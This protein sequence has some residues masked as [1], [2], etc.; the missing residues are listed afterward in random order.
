MAVNLSTSNDAK[1]V[2]VHELVIDHIF[3]APRELVWKA[4]TE[5]ERWMRWWG[6]KGFATTVDKMDV[7][8]G[9]VWQFAQRDQ[10]E[11]DLPIELSNSARRAFD[12]FR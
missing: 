2:A 4:W 8:P 7:R 12:Q 11:S 10:Q 6:P 3:D 5:P 1:D 9:G